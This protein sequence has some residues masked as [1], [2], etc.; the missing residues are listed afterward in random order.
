MSHLIQLNKIDF[1]PSTST[2]FNGCNSNNYITDESFLLNVL[3][4]ASFNSTLTANHKP[5]RPSLPTQ[6]V[7]TI[8]QPSTNH[9][10]EEVRTILK[11][12]PPH[13]FILYQKGYT[14]WFQRLVYVYQQ[15]DDARISFEN[16]LLTKAERKKAIKMC[17]HLL[18]IVPKYISVSNRVSQSKDI[19]GYE[20]IVARDE[21]TGEL[22]KE[23]YEMAIDSAKLAQNQLLSALSTD[24]PMEY[25]NAQI[26]P[27]KSTKFE[28]DCPSHVFVSFKSLNGLTD[29]ID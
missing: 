21:E 3:D 13:I 10:L 29:N 1:D 9:I 7:S 20:S 12:L 11:S 17:A 14:Q 4:D 24:F 27:Q 18:N 25:S 8:I 15:L 2:P 22:F 5:S 28:P 16:E 6:V 23:G 19:A 26:F